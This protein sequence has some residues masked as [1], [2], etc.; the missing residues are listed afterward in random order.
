MP[1][2]NTEKVARDGRAD[3]LQLSAAFEQQGVAG[4]GEQN[5]VTRLARAVR[6]A[7][8]QV[9]VA[10]RGVTVQA[11]QIVEVVDR[12]PDTAWGCCIHRPS[13][14]AHTRRRNT[15]VPLVPPNPKELDIATSIFIGRAVFGT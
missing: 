15:S 8:E 11:R 13:G 7:F 4:K 5:I 2:E 9:R 1:I 6:D 14:F 12:P 3:D 10:L